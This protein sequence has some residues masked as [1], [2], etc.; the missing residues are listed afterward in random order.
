MLADLQEAEPASYEAAAASWRKDWTFDLNF[1]EWFNDRQYHTPVGSFRIDDALDKELKNRLAPFHHGDHVVRETLIRNHKMRFPFTEVTDIN[2]HAHRPITKLVVPKAVDDLDL[3]ALILSQAGDLD[4]T[5]LE[6]F[7]KQS[8]SAVTL[9]ASYR[10]EAIVEAIL[11]SAGPMDLKLTGAFA[12]AHQDV[13]EASSPDEDF[14]GHTPFQA[15]MLHLARY[16]RLDIHRDYKEPIT[17]IIGDTV[18]DFCLYYCLSR[19]HDGVLWLPKK[20]LDDCD[21]RRIN[22]RRLRRKGRPSRDYSEA[23]LVANTLVGLMYRLVEFGRGEKQI[24]LRSM[25]LSAN[26]LKHSLAVMDRI[27]WGGRGEIARQAKLMALAATSTKCVARVIEENNYMNQQEMVFIEGKSVG[28][29]STPKPKNFSLINPANHRWITSVQISGYIPPSLPF[30]GFQVAPTHES[31]VAIDGIVYLCPGIAVFAGDIDANLTRPQ[32]VMISFQEIMRQYFAEAGLE[33]RPSDK[34]NYL[35]DTISRFGGLEPAAKFIANPKTRAILNLFLAKESDRDDRIVYL[36]PEGGRAFVSFAGVQSC[37]GDDAAAII[38]EL[39]GKDILWRGM[40]FL[41]TQCQL[42]SWYDFADLT[43]EFTCRRCHY[44]QQFT[45]AN[46]KSPDEPRWY[47]A[48]VETV[49]QC[50]THNSY[51]TILALDHLRR[52]SKFSFEYLPEM[53][54]INFPGPG[55]NHEID[56]LSMIDGRIAIGECKTEP[57]KPSHTNKYEAL[58]KALT[59]APGEIVFATSHEEV[60]PAFRQKLNVIV[61]GS[62]LTGKDLLRAAD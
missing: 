1:D 58:A 41:C 12:E 31:R 45:K 52:S 7:G 61:G 50:Y 15:S 44:R 34:G 9:P 11:R 48:L 13:P 53:D 62:F 42:S 46:W 55:R 2:R 22:N 30:L 4:A 23:A 21:R 33:L 43:T 26:E 60:S 18:E 35:A 57:L 19:L 24:E 51:L 8:V 38:D 47:Y 29:V 27:H 6:E 32:L 49:Y 59:I 39:V 36:R 28:N 17:A 10:T 25:S 54:V 40:I 37:V 5:A 16:Y 56:I 20:W 14:I 3:R